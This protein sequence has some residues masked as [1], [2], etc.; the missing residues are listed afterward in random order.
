[1]KVIEKQ[2]WYMDE[3]VEEMRR[4]NAQHEFDLFDLS[5]LFHVLIDGCEGWDNIPDERV[6]N[7]YEENIQNESTKLEN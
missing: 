6:V 4:Q 5:D 1:M 7:Y 2:D 3:Q